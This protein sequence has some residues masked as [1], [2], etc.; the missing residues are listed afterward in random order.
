VS[1][2]PTCGQH[3]AEP[4]GPD[5]SQQLTSVA[6]SCNF[7]TRLNVRVWVLRG[8]GHGPRLEVRICEGCM[9]DVRRAQAK[10]ATR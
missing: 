3:H 9:G 8:T 2:C 1:T 5:V 4:A 6:G 7:C 10:V